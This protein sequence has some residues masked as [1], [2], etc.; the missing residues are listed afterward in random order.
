MLEVESLSCDIGGKPILQDVSFRLNEGEYM[1][2]I[3]PNG[4]GKTTL[5]KSLNRILRGYRG[6]I[7]LCGRPLQSYSQ[8]ALAKLMAYVPQ[9]DVRPMPFTVHEFVMMGR[10]PH[11]S[12]F[13]SVRPED[14]D[15]VAQAMALTGTDAFTHRLCNTLSGGERQKVFIA[16]AL[17]QNARIL[18][19]D[20]PTTFLDPHHQDEIFHILEQVNRCGGVSIVAVT[21]DINSA[22]LAA[23]RVLALKKGRVAFDGAAREVMNNRVLEGLFEK[24]FLFARHPVTGDPIVVPEGTPRHASQGGEGGAA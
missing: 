24:P 23:G 20:E 1:A 9:A 15:R 3:G 11:L 16:A 18:L 21:H 12:P 7:R 10:Y 8:A 6:A 5:L 17:A 4:A 14:E 19:L 2:V 13:S 22:V